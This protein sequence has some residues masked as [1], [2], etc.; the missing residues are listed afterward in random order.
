[1]N[2]T[3]YGI[4]L[5]PGDPELLTLKALTILKQVDLIFAPLSR[6]GRSIAADIVKYHL[7]QVRI[8]YL[9]FPMTEDHIRLQAAWLNAVAEVGRQLNNKTVAFVTLGD[10]LLYGTFLYLYRGIRVIY[11]EVNIITVPGIPGMCAVAAAS[12]FYLAAENDRLLLLTGKTPPAMFAEYCRSFETIVIYKPRA[13]FTEYIRNFYETAPAGT[14]VI[15][16]RCGMAEEQIT[17]LSPHYR[18]SKVDYFT[19]AIFHP[20][21]LI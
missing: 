16:E 4:G 5:G 20:K 1:M 2:G 17:Y 6:D 9:E 10:P 12:N 19:I 13:N 3:F 14:G 18:P 21:E 15:I 11:P 7:P 8:Q